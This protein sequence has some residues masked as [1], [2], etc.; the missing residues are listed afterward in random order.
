MRTPPVPAGIRRQ[1]FYNDRLHD[2]VIR[3][4]AGERPA[5]RTLYGLL[6][7]RVWGEAVRLL[8]PGD[9]RAV[10]RSTFVEIW[11]LARHHLDDETGE[12]RGWVLAITARRVYDR[13]RS[14]GGSSSHRDG[15]DHHTHRELVGLLGPGADLSRM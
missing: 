14:G 11:H 10:T 8:P 3:I 7:P 2:L 5:F 1:E 9:A 6:A 15:H 13:T 12:V 4:A